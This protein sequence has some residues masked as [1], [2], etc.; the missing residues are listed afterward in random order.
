M[1]L[2]FYLSVLLFDAYV[3]LIP[4]SD[5]VFVYE[6]FCFGKLFVYEC[7][8]FYELSSFV[9]LFVSSVLFTV[10]MFRI[11]PISVLYFNYFEWQV[12]CMCAYISDYN[13]ITFFH[14]VSEDLHMSNI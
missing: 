13:L 8:T 6:L 2:I 11:L 10:K 14:P 4:G 7:N 1:T 12:V 3:Y 9:Y 5:T